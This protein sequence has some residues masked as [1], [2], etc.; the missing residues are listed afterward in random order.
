M[1]LDCYCFKSTW[2]FLIVK[3][4]FCQIGGV[5][6]LPGWG[7]T[8]QA[9][10]PGWPG[11]ERGPWGQRDRWGQRGPWRQRVPNPSVSRHAWQPPVQPFPGEEQVGAVKCSA[12][13]SAA[14]FTFLWKMPLKRGVFLILITLPFISV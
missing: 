11:G 12:F 9:A 3:W 4:K 2:L 10:Q 13:L 1:C 5:T 7:G 8:G 14:V 6:G